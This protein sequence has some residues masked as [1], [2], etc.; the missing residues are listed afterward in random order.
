[1]SPTPV[2]AP[3][4]SFLARNEFLLRRLH[5]LSGLVP[6]GAY[7]VVHLLTNARVLDSAAAFQNSVYLIH[8]VG[9]LLPVIEWVFIFI[10]LL[11]HAIFGVLIIRGSLPNSG[12][13]KYPR[14]INYTLQR[15]TGMIA[16]VFILWHVFHMHGWIH[17]DW[18]IKGVAE[19][20]GGAQFRAY[21]AS[22]T[23][24]EA[25]QMSAIVPIL[26]AI[27]VLATVFH[28]ANGIWTFG[29]TWG[30]WVTPPAQR[31]ALSACLVF[32]LGLGVVGLSALGGFALMSQEAIDQAVA[33]EE[34]VRLAKE[35]SGEIVPDAH[36]SRP[37]G[38]TAAE[39]EH[40]AATPE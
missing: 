20:L 9:K 5:S 10:P 27:G 19:P 13:Y 39:Q 12:T 24:A 34:K 4:S 35:A 8:S 30:L 1:M 3:A 22:S 17:A 15:A 37:A 6:V 21:N 14:N 16:F 40:A 29:I 11:F 18:W 36:K 28:L 31:W 23:A 2:D 7:M 38:T 25:I 33:H 26:Y 32:G